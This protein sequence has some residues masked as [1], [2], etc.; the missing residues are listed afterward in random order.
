MKKSIFLALIFLVA[1]SVP[2]QTIQSAEP[3]QSVFQTAIAQFPDRCPN[4]T[5]YFSERTESFSPDGLWFGEL[6]LNIDDRYFGLIFSNKKTGVIWKLP[7]ND[8]I[9]K[10]EF[11]DGG[12]RVAHWSK[13]SRYA[14]FH[15]SLGGS[16]GECFYEGYDSGVGVFRLD[17]QTGQTKEILPLTIER[18]YVFSFSPSDKWLVYGINTVNN[19]VIFDIETGFSNNVT[20]KEMFSQSGGYVWSPDGSQF[21]YSTLKYGADNLERESY[22]LRLVDI[23][24]G[25]EQILL[26]SKTNCYLAKKW[27]VDNILQIEYD[28]QKYNRAIMEYD[29]NSNTIINASASPSP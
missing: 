12:M 4:D 18:F 13:D 16:V 22:T 23:K 26:K 10:V 27:E 1:C 14:Y 9:P 21:I 28:D 5:P 19:L 3:T 24:T 25:T 6:C 8:Y 20:H 15:T 29:I 2:E 17:L 11:A 7:Y